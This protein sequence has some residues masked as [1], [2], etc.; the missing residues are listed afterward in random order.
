MAAEGKKHLIKLL[1]D[2]HTA[3]RAAIEG[4]DPEL[5]VYGDT[6]WRIRDIIGHIATWD[7]Q[8]TKSLRA[9]QAGMEYAIPDL[10][11]DSFNERSTKDQGALTAE[12]VY[13]DCEQARQDFIKAVQE[14]PDDSYPGDLLYP[15]G[16]E[17]GSIHKLVHYMVDHD[18]EHREDI[19]KTVQAAK[20]G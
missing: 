5:P 4:V 17:R 9:F 10:D 16:D 2:S 7:R 3:T 12:Q 20:I 8:V 1:T 19:M 18:E 15:W 14:I 6:G 13:A 11:E